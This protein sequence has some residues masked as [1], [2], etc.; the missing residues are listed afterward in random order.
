VV[1]DG[2]RKILV[3]EADLIGDP[4]EG[5]GEPVSSPA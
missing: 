3:L 5:E 1:L 2:R 4:V